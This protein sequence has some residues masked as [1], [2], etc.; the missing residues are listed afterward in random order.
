MIKLLLHIFCI[1]SGMLLCVR[2]YSSKLIGKIL[3][4]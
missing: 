3:D 4:L 1:L 2:V